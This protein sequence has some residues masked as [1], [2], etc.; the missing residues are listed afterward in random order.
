MWNKKIIHVDP[1][2]YDD[3]Y[4]SDEAGKAVMFH[5]PDCK[6]A[7][8]VA[9]FQWWDSSCECHE[10]SWHLDSDLDVVGVEGKGVYIVE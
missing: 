3:V 10:R 6:N 9:E 7:V 2:D 1:V 8:K 4:E 5:C